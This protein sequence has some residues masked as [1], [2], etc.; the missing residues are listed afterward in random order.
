MKHARFSE[1]AAFVGEDGCA[2]QELVGKGAA[3]KNG[4]F[5]VVKT[6]VPPSTKA[7]RHRHKLTEELYIVT[8]GTGQIV[9][10]DKVI[11][12]SAGDA[13]IIDIGERHFAVSCADETLEFLAISLPAYDADDFIVDE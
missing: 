10:D 8:S 2:I 12:V 13:V 7:L 9:V 11:D 4:R 3:I 5:S 1:I 6:V